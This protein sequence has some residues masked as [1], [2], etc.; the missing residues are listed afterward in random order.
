MSVA[1]TDYRLRVLLLEEKPFYEA[2]DWLEGLVVLELFYRLSVRRVRLALYGE[3]STSWRE[4]SD[5]EVDNAEQRDAVA[6]RVLLE[7]Q[8]L[9]TTGPSNSGLTLAGYPLNNSSTSASAG[10]AEKRSMTMMMKVGVHVWPFSIGIPAGL[11][12]ATLA[13]E[14]FGQISFRLEAFV[15]TVWGPD[16][17]CVKELHVVPHEP[18]HSSPDLMVQVP[19]INSIPV[20]QYL[21]FLMER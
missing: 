14:P 4:D 17:G 2:G 12:V 13:N 5:Y 6:E 19:K 15:D 11:Q 8:L 1:D 9:V 3:E 21:F 20:K 18:L 10:G 16:I 7:H